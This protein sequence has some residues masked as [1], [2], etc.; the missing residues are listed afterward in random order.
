MT[1]STFDVLI[2]GAGAIGAFYDTPESEYILSHAHAFS[3]HSGFKLLGFVDADLKRA[4]SAAH[5]WGCKA[6]RSIEDALANGK[7]DIACIAVP[8]ELHYELL[9]RVSVVPLKAVFAE[10]PLTKTVE[11]AE[12]IVKIYGKRDIPVCVNYR[13]SFVPEFEKLRDKI[14][15]DA[16]GRYLTGTGYYGK[17]FLHNG[18]HLIHLLCYLI[19]DIGGHK[20]VASE[21]DFYS[22]DPSISATITFLNKKLFNIHHINCNNYT[23]FE[24]DFLFENGRVRISDTG[25]KIEYYRPEKHN[26][27]KEY[28]FLSKFEKV[29]TQL[30]KSLYY[31]A[32]NIYKHLTIEEPLKCNL[33]DAFKT[34]LI[35]KQIQ[36][37][38][39]AKKF[40]VKISNTGWKA[41]PRESF[42]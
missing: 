37:G 27:F 36:S 32:D 35:C 5:L 19:G 15:G 10:K 13:R 34:M 42:S 22:D 21:N 3:A 30:G 41:D 26:I 29:S 24:A 6:F 31:S 20:I 39:G 4:Q 28:V 8:D 12:E 2:I 16:F 38:K 33:Y 1:V 7:V 17:G 18:S 11:E 14:K 23:I 25:L 9:K 40:Y